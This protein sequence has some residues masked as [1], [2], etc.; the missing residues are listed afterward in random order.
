MIDQPS[1]DTVDRDVLG[2]SKP[3]VMAL[4]KIAGRAAPFAVPFPDMSGLRVRMKD[5]HDLLFSIVHNKA[6]TNVNLLFFEDLR[7][8]PQ[9]DTLDILPGLAADYPNYYFQVDEADIGTFVS[10][11]EKL[12]GDTLS[13]DDVEKYEK[14]RKL[15]PLLMDLAK[16]FGI[17]R[18]RADFWDYNDWV[19][20]QY[21]KEE[22]VESGLVDLNRYVND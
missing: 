16:R 5:Q 12:K 6:H 14:V 17:S 8:Q 15:N 7:R 3:I 2:A 22:P 1:S 11:I 18:Q 10:E 19:N 21:L 4:R 13:R 9:F 20:A